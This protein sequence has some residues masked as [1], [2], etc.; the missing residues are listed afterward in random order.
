MLSE[1]LP[2]NVELEATNLLQVFTLF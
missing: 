2:R 1:K